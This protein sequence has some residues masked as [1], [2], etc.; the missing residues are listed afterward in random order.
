MRKRSSSMPLRMRLSSGSVVIMAHTQAASP[1]ISLAMGR[2]LLLSSYALGKSDSRSP[3]QRT[4]SRAKALPLA[5]PM[6]F[7]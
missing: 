3:T 6:P 1:S 5:S 4:P 2:T 7:I